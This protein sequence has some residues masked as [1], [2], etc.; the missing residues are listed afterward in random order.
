M[1][2][3]LKISIAVTI[4]AFF[5]AC[6]QDDGNAP[7]PPRDYAVQY[8]TEKAAIEEYLNTH[9]I[10]VDANFNVTFGELDAGHPV[11]LMDQ[12]QYPIQQKIV[13]SNNV[14][15]V[16]YYLS[17]NQG[18]GESPT[19]ADNILA[20]YK[21]IAINDERTVFDQ[22]PF[23]QNYS[24]LS[25]A[26]QG[27]QEIIPLFKTG[28][29]N[30]TNPQDP[31]SFS[32]YGAGVMFLPSGLAYYNSALPT[33]GAYTPMIFSFKLYDLEYLDTD[34]DGILNKDEK[35]AFEDIAD[36]DTDNDGKPDYLDTDDDND[37]Y[38]TENELGT[39]AALMDTDGDGKPNHVDD[40][41][42]GDGV[43]TITEG[44]APCNPQVS[45]VPRYLDPA[46]H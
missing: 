15:Y 46:C 39:N 6:K 34:R 28:I 44:S 3:F 8:A 1:K 41:D 13:N 10:E 17:F 7:A 45:T 16:V 26:I 4:V 20:A 2:K 25:D 40:D 9:Y 38:L 37:G 24:L 5:T 19:R 36:N 22:N 29:Y 31:A 30:D 12:T 43:P 21:G 42:D 32:D 23:P 27:W 35:G 14:D 33:V 18:V 11:S